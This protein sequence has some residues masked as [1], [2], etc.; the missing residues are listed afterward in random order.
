MEEERKDVRLL[1]ASLRNRAPTR[2][3]LTKTNILL[4]L[5]VLM[6]LGELFMFLDSMDYWKKF[7]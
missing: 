6:V 1:G 5:L 2:F 3:K 7:Q 4:G